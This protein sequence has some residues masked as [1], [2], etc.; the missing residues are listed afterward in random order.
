[1]KLVPE[2][3]YVTGVP[4]SARQP[5]C[6]ASCQCKCGLLHISW[7]RTSTRSVRDGKRCS[8]HRCADL[9]ESGPCHIGQPASGALMC[10]CRCGQEA[11]CSFLHVLLN[12]RLGG[13]ARTWPARVQEAGPLVQVVVIG[14]QQVAHP[15]LA[16]RH[17]A[18]KGV[19][20]E[21]CCRHNL[22]QQSRYRC[23][24][25]ASTLPSGETRPAMY[26][27]A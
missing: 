15:P 8:A 25:M 7:A 14:A 26:T 16:A 4:P 11:T 27:P 21:G 19:R 17:A 2:P 24:T 22:A 3:G 18:R 23:F 10:A 9:Y 12:V 5:R 20:C 13:K 1:M 6:Q